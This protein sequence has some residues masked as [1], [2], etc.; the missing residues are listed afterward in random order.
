[1]NARI[2][3]IFSSDGVFGNHRR[4]LHALRSSAFHGALFRQL[5]SRPRN[6]FQI[7]VIAELVCRNKCAT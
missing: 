3:C 4:E 1:M 7:L 2:L 6:K 5:G